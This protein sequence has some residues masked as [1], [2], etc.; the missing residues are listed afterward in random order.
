MK[1]YFRKDSNSSNNIRKNI[2]SG[3][4]IPFEGEPEWLPESQYTR[5]IVIFVLNN[6]NFKH[7]ENRSIDL[8]F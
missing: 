2:F 8:W 1:L 3:R 7:L 4:R 6:S 5:N